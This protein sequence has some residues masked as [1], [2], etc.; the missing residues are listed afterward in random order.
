[1]KISVVMPAFN[2]EMTIANAIMSICNQTF[3]DLELII[4]DDGSTDKTYDVAKSFQD[5]RIKAYRHEVNRGIPFA[6][7]F[8]VNQSSSNIIATQDADDL[9]MPDRLEKVY[10]LLKKYDVIFHGMYINKWDYAY[11]CITREYRPAEEVDK[12]KLLTCQYLPGVPIFKKK[13]WRAKPYREET[14]YAHDYMAHLDWILSGFKCTSLDL[15]LYEYVRHS[16]SASIR[17]EREGKRAEAFKKIKQIVK[18]EYAHNLG[19][20]ARL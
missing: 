9:S 15:G 13:V 12:K 20:N 5:P 2:N 19:S 4:I 3:K 16:D 1:M 18:D 6:R 17:F 10:P 7:N 8:G 14:K 11:N